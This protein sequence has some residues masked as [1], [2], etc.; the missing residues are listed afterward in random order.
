MQGMTMSS[1]NAISM[2]AFLL[3]LKFYVRFLGLDGWCYSEVVFFLAHGQLK[4]K[5]G[6]SW[7][8]NLV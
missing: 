1:N 5:N 2:S 4:N 8:P 7:A 6:K 3:Q